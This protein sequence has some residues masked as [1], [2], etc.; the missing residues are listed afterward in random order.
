VR[1]REL[2]MEMGHPVAGRVQMTGFNVKLTGTSAVMRRPAPRLGQHTRAVLRR[3]GSQD[4]A[5]DHL[6]AARAI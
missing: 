6:K 3:L 4:E 1:A 5:I 2:L